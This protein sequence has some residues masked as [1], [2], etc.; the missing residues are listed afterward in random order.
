[1]ALNIEDFTP[2][3]YSEYFQRSAFGI[4]DF[5]KALSATL[6]T[7]LNNCGI[8]VF[9]LAK[10]L[11]IPPIVGPTT[12]D[13]MTPDPVDIIFIDGPINLSAPKN[14]VPSVPNFN[15]FLN[16]AAAYSFGFVIPSR[17]S[18]LV[19]ARALSKKLPSSSPNISPT[20]FCPV[21][22][23]VVSAANAGNTQ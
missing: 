12:L 17:L 23:T 5:V 3:P 4:P 15:L 7:L 9:S 14:A 13:S 16:T 19:L 6:D 10:T 1:M 8:P 2:A 18:N 20:D 22:D 11:D 21:A